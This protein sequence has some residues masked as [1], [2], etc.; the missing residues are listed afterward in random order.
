M[1][2]LQETVAELLDDWGEEILKNPLRF[3]AFL[4]DLHHDQPRE[5]SLLMESIHSG[6]LEMVQQG[7]EK[8]A[9]HILVQK[10]GIAPR[11]AEWTIDF[12]KQLI[13]TEKLSSIQGSLIIGQSKLGRLSVEAVLGRYR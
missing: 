4:R 10:G 5:I 1:S 11:Y 9:V 13:T 2:I 8:E 12:W 3:E 7:E 6:V